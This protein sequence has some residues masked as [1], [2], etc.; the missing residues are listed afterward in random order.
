MIN[1]TKLNILIKNQKV[2][3]AWLL[4][5]KIKDEDNRR[6]NYAHLISSVVHDQTLRGIFFQLP[7]DNKERDWME[8]EIDKVSNHSLRTKLSF[9]CRLY[10]NKGPRLMSSSD[11]LRPIEHDTFEPNKGRFLEL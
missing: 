9:I 8:A 4:T 1:Q 11:L 10:K 3:Q 6:E 7:F 2:Q 5:R